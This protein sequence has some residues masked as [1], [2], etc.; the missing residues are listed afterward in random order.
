[1][2]VSGSGENRNTQVGFINFWLYLNNLTPKFSTYVLIVKEIAVDRNLH[3][4]V[5]AAP[6]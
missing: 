1:M 5:G 4:V 2:I 3:L 6:W